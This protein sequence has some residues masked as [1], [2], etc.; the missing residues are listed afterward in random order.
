[1]GL[2]GG[3][4][5]RYDG[6]CR[7]RVFVEGTTE[8]GRLDAHFSAACA[9]P[10]CFMDLLTEQIEH[11]ISF[12][13]FGHQ[14]RQT[15]STKRVAFA[16]DTEREISRAFS[17]SSSGSLVAVVGNAAAVPRGGATDAGPLG[18]RELIST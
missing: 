9:L 12:E 1:M 2:L 10:A 6:L 8:C 13:D 4:T 17:G 16:F 5:G 11:L 3:L 15:V 7:R 18:S 14:A